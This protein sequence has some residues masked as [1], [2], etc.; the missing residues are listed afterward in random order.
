MSSRVW[1]WLMTL[2]MIAVVGLAI[3]DQILIFWLLTRQ[4]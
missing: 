4:G 3:L 2:A 1:R